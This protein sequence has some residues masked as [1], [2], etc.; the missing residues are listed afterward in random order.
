MKLKPDQ[1]QASMPGFESMTSAIP[2]QCSYK[3]LSYRGNCKQIDLR[4]TLTCNIYQF[5]KILQLSA[6]QFTSAIVSELYVLNGSCFLFYKLNHSCEGY[7]LDLWWILTISNSFY[8]T[9]L[10]FDQNNSTCCTRSLLNKRRKGVFNLRGSPLISSTSHS[11]LVRAILVRANGHS[12]PSPRP[13]FSRMTLTEK[14]TVRF[15]ALESHKM[16]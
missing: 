7:T 9:G 3:Q 6:L 1:I 12:Q 4:N 13:R 10:P 15:P 5:Y 8:S 14:V 2:L 11:I 16:L